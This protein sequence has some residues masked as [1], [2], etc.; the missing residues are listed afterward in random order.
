MTTT[1]G[2]RR[3]HSLHTFHYGGLWRR[4]LCAR[5]H[6]LSLGKGSGLLNSW[7]RVLLGSCC[8]GFF[9]FQ[10]QISGFPAQYK[11]GGQPSKTT[12]LNVLLGDRLHYKLDRTTITVGAPSMLVISTSPASAGASSS[13]W[14][15]TGS[16]VPVVAE[17]SGL[18]S[19]VDAGGSQVLVACCCDTYTTSS[20]VGAGLRLLSVAPP[21]VSQSSSSP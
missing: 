16:T 17:G 2:R 1:P 12:K 8:T 15:T 9:S 7:R 11:F 5:C 18:L 20:T 4:S 19:S 13:T 3:H 14:A 10:G 6:G 21:T